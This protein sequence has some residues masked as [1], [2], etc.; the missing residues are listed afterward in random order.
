[1]G[2][3]DAPRGEG[4]ELV[5]GGLI[6]AYGV[7]HE[8]YGR[9]NEAPVVEPRKSSFLNPEIAESILLEVEPWVEGPAEGYGHQGS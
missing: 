3:V 4:L 7:Q 9:E 1:M 6:N 5:G 8:E 2:T